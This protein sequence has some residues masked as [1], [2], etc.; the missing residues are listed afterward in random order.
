M[1]FNH[2][3]VG[4]NG[5]ISFSSAYNIYTNEEFSSSTTQYVIAPFWDDIDITNGGT[6]TYE[7]FQSGYLLDEVN[8]YIQRKRPTSFEGTWMFIASY[9]KVQPFSGSGEVRLLNCK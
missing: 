7:T 1:F 4:S 2:L 8:A 5:I 6:I 3:Q 9:D